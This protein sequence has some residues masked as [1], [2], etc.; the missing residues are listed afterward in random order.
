M[1]VSGHQSTSG[2][3]ET[4]NEDVR[5]TK[6]D[7]LE[8]DKDVPARRRRATPGSQAYLFV[9]LE[10]ARPTIS[11]LRCSLR[12]V[13]EVTVGRGDERTVSPDGR[14]LAVQLPDGNSASSRARL[15]RGGRD[16]RIEDTGS[17]NGTF[18]NGG[19]IASQILSD[20]DVL[21]VGDAILRLRLALPTPDG[22]SEAVVWEAGEAALG[23]PTLLPAL[24]AELVSA[25]RIARSKVPV[26]LLGDTGTGKEGVARALHAASKRP[27]DFVAVNW[28]AV[29]DALVEAELFGHT[30]GAFSGAARNA[31]GFVRAASGGTL[32]LD[33]VGDL[34]EAAQ[35]V[36]LRVL[37]DGEVV[38]IGA[39]RPVSVDVR[40]I[41]ATHQPIGAM[42]DSG[43]FRRDLFARLHGFTHRLWPLG[44]RREDM[45]GLVADHLQRLAPQQPSGLRIARDAARALVVHSWPLNVRELVHTLSRALSLA[46][47]GVIE[48]EHLPADIASIP[49]AT[50]RETGPP[51]GLSSDHTAV[52]AELVERLESCP[53]DAPAAA[54]EVKKAT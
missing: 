39:T 54:L 34:P 44:D 18:V 26:L 1:R 28:A 3:P 53:G 46:T 7:C 51:R 27:G 22:M 38:P 12:D 31:L 6:Q 32:F 35:G 8:T 52:R 24:A 23:L 19:R 29:P 17:T 2:S 4:W 37:Q 13:A 15:T 9:V 33:E 30:K 41:A 40:V 36:L 49:A 5:G 42:V 20:G 14:R 45:G 10:G 50:P 43:T 25:A 47:D 16:W 48:L 21:E 11:G